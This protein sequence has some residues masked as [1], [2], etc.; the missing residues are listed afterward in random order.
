M[1]IEDYDN[2]LVVLSSRHVC[3]GLLLLFLSESS[4]II[5]VAMISPCTRQTLVLI[6]F[7]YQDDR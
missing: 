1:Y 4:N 2:L 7:F 5:A 6:V 3:L